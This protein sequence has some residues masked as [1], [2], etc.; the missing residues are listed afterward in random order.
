MRSQDLTEHQLSSMVL[1]ESEVRFGQELAGWFALH[2]GV[3]SGTAAELGAAV[4]ARI[5]VCN[6]VWPPASRVLYAHIESHKQVLRSLGVDVGLHP[7]NPRMI[8]LRWCQGKEPAGK[9]SSASPAINLTTSDPLI[10]L[11]PL[12]DDQTMGSTDCG[13]ADPVANETFQ[14]I[15]VVQPEFVKR[16][17]DGESADDDNFRDC[18][19]EKPGEALSAIVEMQG[20]IREQGLDAKL[21]INLVVRCAQEITQCSGV[22]VRLLEQDR[23]VYPARAGTTVTLAGSQY[24]AALFQACLRAGRPLQI[25]DTEVSPAVGAACLRE[26]IRALIIVPIFKNREVAGAMEFVFNEK[27]SFSA[28]DVMDLELIAGTVSEYLSNAAEIGL[29]RAEEGEWPAKLNTTQNLAPQLGHTLNK[30]LDPIDARLGP[31]QG[32]IIPLTTFNETSIPASSKPNILSKLAGV[33]TL[34]WVFLKRTWMKI[35]RAT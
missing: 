30:K 11:V 9:L 7:G 2:G 27:R 34:L 19:F 26:G 33:H 8:S 3:W 10:D 28:V 20:R 25:P 6:D 14:D 18:I 15:P 29:K 4:R 17:A 13:E 35:T 32:T 5:D 31:S 12:P 1:P 16:L 21:A 24:F 22:A 23:V